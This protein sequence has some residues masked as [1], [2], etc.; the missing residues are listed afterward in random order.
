MLSIT[1][2]L[3][4]L[5]CKVCVCLSIQYAIASFP[6]LCGILLYR[7]L[8]SN[9]A[10]IVPSSTVCGRELRKC[11]L[12][13]TKLLTRLV[14]GCNSIS[15]RLLSLLV[16]HDGPATMGLNVRSLGFG[17]LMYSDFCMLMACLTWL[18]LCILGSP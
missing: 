9:V 11:V 14:K 8:T 15:I 17:V 10:S 16:G 3:L 5:G 13:L 6:R 12:S 7:L 4:N 18:D 1:N 2:C